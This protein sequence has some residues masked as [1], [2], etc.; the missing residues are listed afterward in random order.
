[1]KFILTILLI[2]LHFPLSAQY[3]RY[4]VAFTDKNGTSHQLDNPSTYLSA[5]SIARRLKYKI[6]YDSTDLPV[7]KIY[8]DS[9]IKTGKV[10]IINTS[11]WLNQVLIQTT[12]EVALAKIN[13]FS[14]VRKR[15]AVGYRPNNIK[16]Q[17]YIEEITENNALNVNMSSHSSAL[18]YGNSGKQIGLHSGEFLHNIGFK[19][20]GISIAI[21]DGGFFNYQSIKAFDSVRLSGNIKSTWDFIE[22]NEMVN[23]DDPHGMYCF[24][25]LAGNLSGL[26]IGSAPE[27]AYYLYRT[28]D[29]KTEFPV[30]E[31]YW[32]VA[33]ERADSLGID[34]ISSSLG[35]TTFDDPSMNY[36]YG[37][38]NGKN[39]SIT[40]AA[41]LAFKKGMIVMNS[42]GN[43][44]TNSWKFIGAPADGEHVLAVGA[45]NATGQVA[46]F[47]SF[48]PSFD[49][50][51]K[52]DIASVGWG[53]SLISSNGS[54][55]TGNGTSF[56]NPNIAGLIA[57]L[58]QAFPE[59]SN[60][61][62]ITA[63][64]K[65]G[66]QYLNPDTRIGFGI[67]DM[68]KAFTLLEIQRISKNNPGLFNQSTL[69]AFPNP[70]LNKIKLIYK[71]PVSGTLDLRMLDITGKVIRKETKQILKNE[72]YLFEWNNLE[73]LQGGAYFITYS[74]ASGKNTIRLVK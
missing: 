68:K 52:P 54:A 66:S 24:S 27:S 62:I 53:T 67:P 59:M 69:K 63:V 3:T 12:D 43:S 29:V 45:V 41:E 47:S 60:I 22:N 30:E 11:K 72:V 25:I 51:T 15:K 10:T 8:L 33:A 40:K 50:R 70:F 36:N 5:K 28:E 42:A 57:C 44:G 48:G 1:M 46:P 13:T 58:W 49:Q 18:N 32:A 26:H 16:S 34:M 19:G 23:E 74:D 64:K 2:A 65:S 9:I 55:A 6:S 73:I 7:S 17:D 71:A 20:K 14:F 56:S 38:M 39:T 31:Q 61:D 35:Y 21:L 4:I 37:D